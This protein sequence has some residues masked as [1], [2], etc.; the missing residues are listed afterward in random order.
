MIAAALGK[1]IEQLMTDKAMRRVFWKALLLSIVAYIASGVI[2]YFLA[3]YFLQGDIPFVPGFAEDWIRPF[4]EGAAVLVVII[5]MGLVFPAIVTGIS[6]VFLDE[7]AGL[8]ERKYYPEDPPG[9]ELPFQR[10]LIYS[11]KFMAL[12]IVINILLLPVYVVSLFIVGLGIALYYLVNGYFLGRE[13]FE[14]VA[15]RHIPLD[16]AVASRRANGMRL[17]LTGIVIAFALTIPIVNL[18][19]PILGIAMLVHIYKGLGRQGR[20][21][22]DTSM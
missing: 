8:V 10:A 19:S 12:V 18:I 2:A 15:L 5:L 16:Q 14:T 4:A 3:Q 11:L 1:A 21:V 9:R 17:F 22:T 6:G 13:Y 7:V 20:L